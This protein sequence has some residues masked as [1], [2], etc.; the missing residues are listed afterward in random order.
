MTSFVQETGPVTLVERTPT[1]AEYR[2]LCE[3]VGWGQVMNF[4]AAAGALPRSLH[5]V[6]ACQGSEVVGMGR[7]VGDGAIFFYI[8]DVAVDPRVQGQGIGRRILEAL[9]GWVQA[10]A[11][12]KAFLGLFAASGALSFYERFGFASHSGMVGMFQVVHPV[13]GSRP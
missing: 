2:R 5:A 7:I 11:P 13:R 9:V 3:S 10:H 6:V 8:Q 12:E 4:E 1:P